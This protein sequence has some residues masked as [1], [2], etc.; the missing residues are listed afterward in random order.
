MA[1]ILILINILVLI[2]CSHRNLLEEKVQKTLKEV[3]LTLDDFEEDKNIIGYHGSLV[4]DLDYESDTLDVVD[5]TRN[6]LF[7]ATISDKYNVSCGL[8]KAKDE[9]LFIFCDINENIPKGEHHINLNNIQFNYNDEYLVTLKARNS[10]DFTKL[11]SDIIDLYADKQIINLEEGKDSY[12]LK[13]KIISYNQEKIFINYNTV[14]DNCKKEKEELICPISK[15]KLIEIMSPGVYGTKIQITYLNTKSDLKRFV[16]IPY[17]EVQYNFQKKDIFVG[18]KKLIENVAEHDTL[19]AY[20]TNITDIDNIRLDLEAFDLKFVSGEGEGKDRS[21]AFRK[22]D[23]TPL[24]IVCWAMDGTFWLKKIE[25]ELQFEE[26]LN[27]KY[28]FRIQPVDNK[29]KIYSDREFTGSFIFWVY[30]ETLDF[31]KEDSLTIDYF[32]ENPDAVN[33]MTFNENAKDLECE[34]VGR[35]IKRCKVPKSH[36]KGKKTG[37]YFIKHTNHLNKKSVFYEAPPIKIILSSS[38]G[39]VQKYSF[40]YIFILLLLTIF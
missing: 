39:S 1:K 36:F 17:I 8:W 9:K 30:P 35:R 27:M 3:N 40:I 5:T 33:G 18:I 19:I 24:L 20:E 38:M 6:F 4:L 34:E 31:T 21:C 28:N 10:F 2:F 32:L 26:E 14:I 25:K 11:D 16:L 23:E 29:E 13:F 37:Y 12:D 22:Y 15:S 7:K